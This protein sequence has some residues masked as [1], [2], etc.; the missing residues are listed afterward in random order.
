MGM[1]STCIRQHYEETKWVTGDEE[2]KRFTAWRN[3]QTG[4]PL[5]DAG[6]RELYTTG[7]MNQSVRMVVASFLVEYLRVNWKK[8]CDWFHQSLVDAD[9]AINPMMWQN[10]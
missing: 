10:A 5:V 1:R 4:Y 8:G 2:K 6:M 9:S 7:W 3:G